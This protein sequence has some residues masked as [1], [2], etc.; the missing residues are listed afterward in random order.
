MTLLTSCGRCQMSNRRLLA[1]SKNFIE[2]GANACNDEIIVPNIVFNQWINQS[3]TDILLARITNV[4]TGEWRIC[5]VGSGHSNS[6]MNCFVPAWLMETLGMESFESWT[7][8]EI[9]GR[10][11]FPLPAQKIV[12]RPMDAAAF[13]GDVRAS[14]ETGL[15]MWHVIQQGSI[16]EIEIGDLDGYRIKAL[17]EQVEPSGIGRL[18]GEVEVEFIE[19]GGGVPPTE[20]EPEPEPEPAPIPQENIPEPIPAQ[21][22]ELSAS[23]RREMIRQ[24]WL[25]AKSRL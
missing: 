16:I 14:F 8:I 21:V 9:L 7:E 20:P 5:C 4:S 19:P 6:G 11:E 22:P 23:E 24:S 15:D 3:D 10:E 2:D 18:G 1:I 17:I 12:I 25:K 13:C